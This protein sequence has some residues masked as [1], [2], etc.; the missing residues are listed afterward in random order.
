MDGRSQ[1]GGRAGRKY[2]VFVVLSGGRARG[3]AME[4]G[5]KVQDK[6]ARKKSCGAGVS[7]VVGEQH[8]VE[9]AGMKLM[10]NGSRVSKSLKI[11][12]AKQT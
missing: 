11:S 4:A 7:L 6:V 9:S 2:S 1:L 3:V 5:K 8:V 12:V 10:E